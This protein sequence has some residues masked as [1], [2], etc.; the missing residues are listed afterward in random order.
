[1]LEIFLLGGMSPWETFYTVPENGDPDKGG[2]YAGQ[3]W[4][5]FQTSQGWMSIPEWYD[6]CV[7]GNKPLYEPFATD[8][9]GKTVNLGPLVHALRDR[10]D[11]LA[12]MRVWVMA[13]T[14]EPHEV[15]IPFA[16]AGLGLGNLRM[17]GLGSHLQR[18]FSD[19]A[20]ASRVAPY[21]YT[22]NLS[23]I[24]LSH[25]GTG[26]SSIGLHPAS[27]QPIGLQLGQDPRMPHLL[28]RPSTAGYRE[29]LDALVGYYTKRFQ[30]RL[31]GNNGENLRAPG[32]RDFTVAR[33]SM[34]NHAILSQLLSEE[35]FQS[36]TADL[37]PEHPLYLG[38]TTGLDETTTAIQMARHLLT[39]G[40]NAPKYVQVLDGGLVTDPAGQGYDSHG[41]HVLQ[42]GIN[43][44]HMC[45][46]L[47][48][49]VNKPGETD[50]SKLD[51]DQHFVLLNTEFG[52]GPIPEVTPANPYGLGTNHW[53]WGYV[54]VGFG[55]FVDEERSGVVGAI[56]EDSHA[57]SFFTPTEHRAAML[58]AMG[59][60]PFSE[61]SFAVSEV[62]GATSELEAALALKAKVLGYGS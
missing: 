50:S 11:M 21:S 56:G 54:V 55:G 8:A 31:T 46:A 48:D 6:Q 38:T 59:V 35:L 40:E 24:N 45:Q 1:M 26:A 36:K 29:H 47:S 62:R 4:W 2:A 41:A 37:C 60:W 53:P 15:A 5:S 12:R 43:V 33:D 3:Q 28:R 61:E 13:H 49:I 44:T 32:F 14:V 20:P 42:Q 58:L 25:D 57:T 19:K 10:P 34:T 23:T 30:A 27:A 17:A 9:A 7:G 39:A 51:L 16:V 22:I 52:R 18:H